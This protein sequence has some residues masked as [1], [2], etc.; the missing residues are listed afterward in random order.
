MINIYEVNAL[1]CLHIV[2]LLPTGSKKTKGRK[3][4]EEGPTS[5][6]VGPAPGRKAGA[7]VEKGGLDRVKSANGKNR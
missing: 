5:A 2:L 7:D 1:A 6:K 4:K 3:V